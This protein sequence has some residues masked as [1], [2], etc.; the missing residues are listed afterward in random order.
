MVDSCSSEESA[1]QLT[2]TF[3]IPNSGSSLRSGLRA[4]GSIR[5]IS[6][7]RNRVLPAQASPK[8]RVRCIGTGLTVHMLSVDSEPPLAE[9]APQVYGWSV[10]VRASKNLGVCMRT[11]L[12]LG[13][14]AAP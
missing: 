14:E 8:P 6:V 7:S 9:T 1:C 5:L 4:V 13:G 3:P 2:L 12:P 11:S 10:Q